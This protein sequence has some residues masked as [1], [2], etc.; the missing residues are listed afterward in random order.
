MDTLSVNL[1]NLCVPFCTRPYN[2]QNK[3]FP[4]VGV[5]RFTKVHKVH[6]RQR[7]QQHEQTNIEGAR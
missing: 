4:R 3:T 1:V 7:R 6:T 2:T 5:E